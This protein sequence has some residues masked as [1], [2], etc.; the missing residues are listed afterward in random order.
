MMKKERNLRLA[1]SGL[2]L[3]AVVAAGIAMYRIDNTTRNQEP[4]KNTQLAEETPLS[5]VD[6]SELNREVGVEPGEE[7]EA[8]DVNTNNVATADTKE[9]TQPDT[10]AN[11]P[12]ES[13]TSDAVQQVLPELSYSEGTE[14]IWPIAQGDVLIDYSMDA[15]VYFPTLDVYKYSPALV[16]SSPVDQEVHAMANSKVV[17]VTENSETGT[18]V[19]MD[20]GNGYQ[21]VY[22]QL[23]DVKVAADETVETGT[24]L[25]TI[26]EPTKYY[27]KEGSNLYLS[28]TKDGEA[29]DPML[30]LPTNEE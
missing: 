2:L 30:Y 21:V 17:S 9:E 7:N 27:S 11:E 23:K 16:M 8:A 25:G 13:A 20:M 10:S 6:D 12:A 5:E 1:L 19:T 4:Q 24:L 18:T 26:S 15:S 28:M 22:G 3:V 29:I 14:T